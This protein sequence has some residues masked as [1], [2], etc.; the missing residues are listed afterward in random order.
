MVVQWLTMHK[1]EYIFHIGTAADVAAARAS[2][3][4]SAPSLASEGFIHLSQAHQVRAVLQAFYPGHT[5]LVLMVVDP[6]LLTAPLRFE[7]PASLHKPGGPAAFERD[8]LFPHLYG[9]LNADAV[10]ALVDAASFDGRPHSA[11]THVVSRFAAE[12]LSVH[13]GRQRETS[14]QLPNQG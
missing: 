7:A 12:M 4:H 9:P 8:Q 10:V 6:A 5:D 14:G 11:L 1:S 3:A 2:G 13:A